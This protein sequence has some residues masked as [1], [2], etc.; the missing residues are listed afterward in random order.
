MAAMKPKTRGFAST[1]ASVLQGAPE[2]AFVDH[3]PHNAPAVSKDTMELVN[4]MELF[5]KV[6][7]LAHSIPNGGYE[8]KWW[9]AR[10]AQKLYRIKSHVKCVV[11]DGSRICKG[12]TPGM[13]LLGGSNLCPKAID[14]DL[15]VLIGGDKIVDK[16]GET[17]EWLWNYMCAKSFE[18]YQKFVMKTNTTMMILQRQPL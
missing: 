13:A 14:S 8:I 2:W 18:K 11:F 1:T 5:P 9:C 4:V 6:L 15:D 17:F 7:E 12:R 16:V 10:D 3:L